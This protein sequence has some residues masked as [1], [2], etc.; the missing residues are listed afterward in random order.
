MRAAESARA[1]TRAAAAAPG[2]DDPLPP[3]TIP[4]PGLRGEKTPEGF[5]GENIPGRLH[6]IIDGVLRSL[7]WGG[8]RLAP[9]TD[10]ARCDGSLIIPPL[11][12]ACLTPPVKLVGGRLTAC[13]FRAAPGAPRTTT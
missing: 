5:R 11:P 4:L 6:V 9:P 7:R 3:L 2:E 8:G 1:R 10:L 13:S 12:A